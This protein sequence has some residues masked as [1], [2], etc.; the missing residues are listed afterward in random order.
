M[1]NFAVVV[2]DL[3][4][5]AH[6]IVSSHACNAAPIIGKDLPSF[7]RLRHAVFIRG[8]SRMNRCFIPEI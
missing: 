7:F 6:A 1:M 2:G 4:A 5:F 3:F 8:A